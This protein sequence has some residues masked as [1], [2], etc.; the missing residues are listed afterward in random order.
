MKSEV[1]LKSVMAL[2]QGDATLAAAV[3]GNLRAPKAAEPKAASP[4]AAAASEAAPADAADAAA[5]ASGKEE[6]R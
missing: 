6:A 2:L 5:V 1:Q 3:L 4:A